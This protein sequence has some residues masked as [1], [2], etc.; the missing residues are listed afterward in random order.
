VPAVVRGLIE[1]T[2]RACPPTAAKKGF[3]NSARR[4]V[5]GFDHPEDLGHA[6]WRLFAGE[7]LR[8]QLFTPAA[9]EEITTP[10]GAHITEL[11]RQACGRDARDRALYVDLRSYLVDNCLV[12]VDRMS[13]AC[14]LETRV[15][16][17]DPELVELAFRVP[18]SLKYSARH[19][20]ILLKRVAS[21]HVPEDCVYRPKQGF[22]IPI[23][24]WLRDEFRPLVDELLERSRIEAEGLF[25][26]W[27]VERLKREHLENSANH[28]HVLWSLLVFQDWRRR[29]SV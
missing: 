3:V 25:N 20:K 19:T 5:E 12:K 24:N 7:A 21:R 1:P 6:R 14:S 4:F 23:K 27:M 10:V 13:M 22:S 17:L 29:W 18:S 28:S 15:P 26:P 9:L 8:A 11:Q 2:V 16:L